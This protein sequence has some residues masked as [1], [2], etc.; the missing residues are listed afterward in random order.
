MPPCG[1]LAHVNW[2][3]FLTTALGGFLTLGGGLLGAWWTERRARDRET[4][5]REH[6]REVWARGLRLEAHGR[7]LDVFE[8]KY[9]VVMNAK[10][11]PY[12]PDPPED[13]LAPVWDAFQRLRI[14]CDQET[15][16]TAEAVIK[17]LHEYT[18]GKGKWEQVEWASEQYLGAIRR[19]FGLK[20]IE[21]MGD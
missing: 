2:S 16:H 7:F 3:A 5:A 21:L 15:A 1:N 12:K 17:A 10:D 13:W 11:D 8:A 14:V 18:F 20:Q 6:E 4:R 9:R 19:E